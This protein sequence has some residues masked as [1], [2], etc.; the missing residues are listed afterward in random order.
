MT[1]TVAAMTA[2]TTTATSGVHLSP[3]PRLL[4]LVFSHKERLLLLLL[5]LLQVVLGQWC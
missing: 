2:A 3:L 1:A 5:L 4:S